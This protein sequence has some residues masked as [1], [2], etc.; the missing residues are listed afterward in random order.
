MLK[1]SS[2]GFG[3][4]TLCNTAAGLRVVSPIHAS[5]REEDGEDHPF[6][7]AGLSLGA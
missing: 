7:G 2:A 1:N 5:R 4:S 6:G 3:M